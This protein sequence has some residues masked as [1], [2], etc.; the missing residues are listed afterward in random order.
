[1]EM[2]DRKEERTS[3]KNTRAGGTMRR[4]RRY[5]H[6]AKRKKRVGSV[7]DKRANS[8]KQSG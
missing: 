6:A 8:G 1:M 7:A 5:W 3:G 4:A 2:M